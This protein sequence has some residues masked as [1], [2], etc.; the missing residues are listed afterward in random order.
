MSFEEIIKNLK[1]K[2][3]KP[4]YF[5]MGEESYF[6]DEI[7]DYIEQNILDAAEKEFNQTVLYGK[8]VDVPTIISYAKRFPMMANY[9]VV[10]VKEAQ[11]LKENIEKL[12]P[13]IEKPLH[14]TILVICYRYGKIDKRKGF[15]KLLDKQ[16]VLFESQKIYEN[17]VPDWINK[18]LKKLNYGISTKAAQLLAEYLG[19]DLGLISNELSKLII[20]LPAGTEINPAH[21]EQ[22]IGISKDYNVFELCRALEQRNTL[23]ANQIVLQFA[24]NEKENP[25]QKVLYSLYSSFSKILI[26][27][28]IP[29]KSKNN[30]AAALGINP[31]F[32]GD[33]AIAAKNYNP[34]KLFRIMSLLREY[35]VKSK[36]V[37]S[38]TE[39]PEL[40]KELVFK[41]QH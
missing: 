1:N 8:D 3:Y 39:G 11:V 2:V 7:S 32:V 6:I 15:A 27:H 35:D 19:N 16:G 23:R 30:V 40:M 20:N 18:H 4:V 29:D 9:Q 36:G 26:Y 25:I 14:S 21:I 31:Y 12:H 33:Y 37:D 10:I 28:S 38:N 24:Q 34:A 22:N 41:I 5:L 13:Y 17:Q